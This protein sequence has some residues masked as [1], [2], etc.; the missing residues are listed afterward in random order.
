MILRESFNLVS[1]SLGGDISDSMCGMGGGVFVVH[2]SITIYGGDG[3]TKA[4][5]ELTHGYF[6]HENVLLVAIFDHLTLNIRFYFKSV[7]VC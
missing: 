5:Y 3:S 1:I 6:M 2:R 7:Y 4:C